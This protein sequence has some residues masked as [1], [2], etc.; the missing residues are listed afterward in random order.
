MNS[1]HRRKP[2][3]KL[4]NITNNIYNFN[5]NGSETEEGDSLSKQAC[6][7]V[8]TWSCKPSEARDS[9]HVGT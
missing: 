7:Q 2:L 5:T 9:R 1:P 6:W 4:F 8:I 3:I